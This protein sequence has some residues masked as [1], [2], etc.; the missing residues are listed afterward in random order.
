M[1]RLN[2]SYICI[3]QT[4]LCEVKRR[5][6]GDDWEVSRFCN[7]IGVSVV[8]GFS[9][10]LK[11]FVKKN[12]PISTTTFIDMRYGVGCYLLDLG[13]KEISTHVSFK[14]TD[15]VNTYPRTRFLSNAG[16]EKGLVKIWDCGQKKFVLTNSVFHN[17]SKN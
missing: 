3:A 16:Y 15:C 11:H 9:K 13:F 14:W 10:L 1:W 5:K 7:K 2:Y 4:L 12:N 6:K 8:G 17:E